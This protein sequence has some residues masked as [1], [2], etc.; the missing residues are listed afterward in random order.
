LGV[1]QLEPVAMCCYPL[2]ILLMPSVAVNF[3]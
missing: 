2:D 1:A 3:K